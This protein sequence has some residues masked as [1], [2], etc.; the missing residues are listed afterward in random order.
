[1]RQGWIS[2][3][4]EQPPCKR[5][6]EGSNPSSSTKKCIGMCK[7]DESKSFCVGCKRTIEEIVDAGRR[8]IRENIRN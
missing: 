3:V 2:S 7:L 6:V 4:V 5:Q 8:V 1:M